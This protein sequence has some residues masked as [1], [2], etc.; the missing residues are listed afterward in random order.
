MIRTDSILAAQDVAEFFVQQVDQESGDNITNLKLQKLLYY[1]Q[2]FHLAMRHGDPLFS[3][4]ISAWKHGPVVRSVYLRYKHLGWQPI[5]RSSDFDADRFLP[6][7]QEILRAV[8][9][10]YGQFTATKL[11]SMTHEEPPWR[12][13]R[14]QS[15]ITRDAMG[16]YFGTLVEA[17]RNGQAVAGRPPWPINSFRFQQRRELADRLAVHRPALRAR[18]RQLSIDDD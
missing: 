6:E 2:G 3:E 10:T 11:E 12:K 18:A 7:V 15:V 13:T 4:S 1:A 16:K 14:P 17:G 8:Y 5:G 9:E